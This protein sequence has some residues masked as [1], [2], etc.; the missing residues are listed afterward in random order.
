MNTP[1]IRRFLKDDT[2]TGWAGRFGVLNRAAAIALLSVFIFACDKHDDRSPIETEHHTEKAAEQ[3]SAI[4]EVQQADETPHTTEP[5]WSQHISSHSQGWVSAEEPLRIRFSHAVTSENF[6][7]KDLAN[8][9]KTEPQLPLQVQF[10]ATDELVIHHPKFESGQIVS[11]AFIPNNDADQV[12]TNIPSELTPFKFQ[13][14]ALVQDYELNVAGLVPA[15]D[16]VEMKL[17]GSIRTTDIAEAKRIEKTISLTQNDTALTIEWSHSDDKLS[18]EFTISGIKRSTTGSELSLNYSAL[19]IGVKKQGSY[20]IKVPAINQFTITGVRTLQIPEQ[21]VEVSF[22]EALDRNQNLAGLVQLDGEEASTRIDGSYLRIYPPNKLSGE[23]TLQIEDTIK[24]AKKLQLNQPYLTK[25]TFISE[26][27]GVRFASRGSILPPGE[28]LSVP[29][30]A[31]NVNAVWVTAFKVYAKN[32]PQFL[33][34]YSIHSQYTDR[35][36]GRYLWRKKISLPSVPFDEWQHFDIDM[37][38]VLAKHGDGIINLSIHIDRSTAAYSCPESKESEQEAQLSSYDGPG[39][40]EDRERPDWFYNYYSTRNGYATYNERRDPCHADFYTYYNAK[41]VKDARNFIVSDI[42]LLVK[43]GQQ[44]KLHIL[45]TGIQSGQPKKDVTILAYNYQHQLIGLGESDKEGLT[46]ISPKGKAFYVIAEHKKDRAYIRLPNNEALPT[47]Q[48]DVGGEK[49]HKGLKGFIYGERDIWRPGDDIFLTFLLQD[50][51]KTIPKGHPVSLD[52]FNPKGVKVTTLSNSKPTGSLY[53]FTLKTE[54]DA[55]TGNWRAVVRV[56]GEY[57]SKILKIETIV[58]N[59]L[60]VDLKP[61]QRPMRLSDSPVRTELFAQW[62]NGATAKNLK[63]DSE[64]KLTPK[65]TR[66]DGWSQFD[67]DD[68]ASDFKQ[69]KNKVF[70]GT[71]DEKGKAVFNVSLDRLRQAPGKLRA[72]FVTRVFE[73][74]GNFS[75]SIRNE[76]VL[77]FEKW[78]GLNIPKGDGYRDA[79]SRDKDHRIEFV[80]IDSHGKALK[81]RELDLRIYRIGWR[82]WWDQSDENL[83]NYIRGRHNSLV[84]ESELVTNDNGKA[85]FTLKKNRYS[86][87]R[88]LVRVCDKDSGHCAG[89]EVYLGWSW[90]N[91][92]NPDAATQ[93]MLATDKDKYAVGETAIIRIPELTQGRIFYSVENGS[94]VLHKSWANVASGESSFSIPITEDMAPNVYVNAV[95]ILPHLKREADAPI[96]MYGITPLHVDNP[97]SHIAPTISAPKKVRPASTFSIEVAEENNKAMQYT[98]AVVDEGLLGITGFK[99]PNPHSAFY[100]REALGVKTWDMFDGVIGAY[101]ANLERLLRIGGGD[102]GKGGKH[103]KERRFPPVVKF[104]GA[105][106]L[107]AGEKRKHDITL[108]QYMGAV[109]VMVVAAQDEAYGAAEQTIT[110]TQ[111]LTLLATLPRVLG[112]KEKVALPVNVFVSDEAIKEVQVEVITDRLFSMEKSTHSFIFN[113]PGDQIAMLQMQVANQIGTGS[114]TVIATSGDEK[115]EQRIHIESRSPNTRSDIHVSKLLEP[116]ESWQ[117]ELN[118]H[119][120]KNTNIATLSVSSFPPMNLDNRLRYLIRYPHG[121]LEQ[122][123]SAIFPQIWL[124]NIIDLTDGQKNEIEEYVEIAIK[125]YSNFQQS[126]GGFSYW[127]GGSY[128]NDWAT[129]YVTHFLIEAKQLGYAVP[130]NMLEDATKYL[131]N[132]ANKFND[133]YPYSRLVSAYR[134]YVLSLANKANLAAMNRLREDLLKNQKY[135]DDHVARWILSLAY[136]TLGLQDVAQALISKQDN[137]IK[138]YRY[139]DYTYGSSLRDHAILLMTYQQ[140]GYKEKAW[141][142]AEEIAGWLSRDSWYSTHTTAWA[143]LALSKYAANSSGGSNKIA[144]SEQADA[145]SKGEDHWQNINS[146]SPVFMQKVSTQAIEGK[147]FIIRNDSDKPLHALLN[148][149]GIP[150]EGDERATS[151]GLAISTLFMDTNGQTLDPTRLPQGQDF[152]AQVSIFGD[153][154]KSRYKI[155]D[156]A[157][158][159]IM[160]SGWQIRNERLEGDAVP[161]GLDYQDIRDDRVLSYF[162]LWK[163]YYWHYRYNDR[164]RDSQTIRVVLNASFAGKFYLPGWQVASMYDDKIKATTTGQWVEVIAESDQQDN[165]NLSNQGNN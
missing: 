93:L 109:R 154:S 62:L 47:S 100:K 48:F 9:V 78:V 70:S 75:T 25:V 142:E 21:Y 144:L 87:G 90:S 165:S 52:L 49:I 23:L 160:P 137:S 146:I 131:N 115:A 1:G 82:W 56:G 39:M 4:E 143:L 34:Q 113:E 91:Q 106:T 129:N 68:P 38:E 53:S 163:D 18:H 71:L 32:I 2:T 20:P 145:I 19:D 103:K 107:E 35:E 73:Q 10:T 16:K 58:P 40:S 147:Q 156:I 72:T 64:L 43:K 132:N 134:L 30:E 88:H 159:M 42:G 13:V 50:K 101:G 114:V 121:C 81:D 22:S 130:S 94:E 102:E 27:P 139:G 12:L 150:A 89:Q 83:A 17:T 85:F 60:K 128:A 162:S 149:S 69:Y 26:L 99:A 97:N 153:S 140:N 118:L 138:D 112:P 7:N 44:N 86:W 158:T 104:L 105:F 46:E 77:P 95:L 5:S 133:D 155:E 29:I 79:I 41:N 157:M 125:K 8:I 123:T 6:L 151:D 152:I 55:P 74:S 36:S 61:S 14:Q 51:Q 31:I 66:F 119:G 110:V 59:R 65:S 148:N 28:S 116:G 33:Q 108:P 92:V 135:Y 54:E 126:S 45:T 3:D 15:N 63:A 11:I 96:R 136:N 111:P 67:F 80:S 37:K 164:N 161:E 57:F 120:M 76:E 84:T 124:H 141:N 122:T 127:P 24:S 98:V 117:P